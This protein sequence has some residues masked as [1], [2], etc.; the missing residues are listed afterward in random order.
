MKNAYLILLGTKTLLFQ[1]SHMSYYRL[2]KK[3]VLL[4]ESREGEVSTTRVHGE[5]RLAQ[6]ATRA[7]DGGAQRGGLEH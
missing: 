3:F 2:K 6:V 7:A 1:F 4:N 5:R